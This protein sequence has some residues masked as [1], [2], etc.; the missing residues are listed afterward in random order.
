MS[1]CL[2]SV[3]PLALC[4]LAPLA[5]AQAPYVPDEL[6]PWRDWVLHDREYRQCPFLYNRAG[7]EA[8]DFVCAWPGALALIVDA[9]GGTFSQAWTVYAADQWLVIPGDLSYWP[10]DVQVD[11]RAASVVLHEGLPSLR[12]GPGRY[13]VSGRFR[14][15]QRPD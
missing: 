9:N 12:L 15:E 11:G 10:E 1:K 14:W 8:G 7:T 2:R 5:A 4:M 13:S 3:I 6:E